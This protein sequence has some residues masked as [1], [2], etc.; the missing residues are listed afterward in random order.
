MMISFSRLQ[1][2]KILSGQAGLYRLIALIFCTFLISNMPALAEDAT[3][4]GEITTPYPTVTNLAVEWGIAGDDNLNGVV[5]VKYRMA[6]QETWQEAMPLVRVPAG[7]PRRLTSPLYHWEN[8]HSGSIFDLKP[9]TEYEIHLTLRDPD[10]GSAQQVVRAGTRPVPGPAVDAVIKKVTP[11]TFG[12]SLRLAKAGDILLLSPGYYRETAIERSGEPDRPIVI[13][14]DGAHE[15]IGST[16]DELSLQHCRHLIVEG[17]TV[18][19]TVNLRFARDVAVR[20]CKVNAKYGIIAKESPG[21]RNCY[22]ADNVVSYVMPWLPEGGGSRMENWGAACVGEGIE[23]TGP[24]NVICYN[25]VTGYRDCISTMEGHRIYDQVCIDIY[26]NDI[27]IGADDAIE[28][29]F[30]MHNCRVLRN[31]MTNCFIA[32]SG[33]PSLGGPIYYIRNV[34]Y[35]IVHSPFKLERHSVGNLFIHNTCVKV[36]DGFRVFH[37]QNEYFRTSFINNLAIGGL[38]GGKYGRYTSGTG[39]ALFAP[40]LNETCTFDYNGLGTYRTPFG[41]QVADKVFHDIESL[42]SLTGGQHSVQVGMDVFEGVVEFPYPA[43][44]Q[45]EPADLRLRKGSAAVDAGVKIANLNDSYAGSAPDLG[46][47]ELG[48]E[49]PHYGPRPQG[50]DEETSWLGKQR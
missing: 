28:A 36:G 41:G 16:F 33:Q 19:G 9:D 47:Y 11:V 14:A 50:V 20:R 38:G 24:G 46:A 13:R 4:P 25:R 44:P 30:C 26:N 39:L 32:L 43:Y 18:N 34:M 48:Q 42:K 2:F 49:L 21:C 15:V 27:Y 37:G 8:K 12:D 35:N 1:M 3:V 7:Y 6:G 22:I 29:D 23:V 40:G 45:R 10:G 17:L 31:R 5:E